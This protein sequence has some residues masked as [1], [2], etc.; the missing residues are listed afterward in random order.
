MAETNL[1]EIELNNAEKIG[2]NY[3]II[4]ATRGHCQTPHAL[5]HLSR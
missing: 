2:G 3:L 1:I 4:K 5:G